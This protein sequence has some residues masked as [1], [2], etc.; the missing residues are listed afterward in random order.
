M[1]QTWR[2]GLGVIV[3]F[4]FLAGAVALALQTT[5]GGRR[6]D[7]DG[8]FSVREVIEENHATTH[9]RTLE[10]L[11]VRAAASLTDW[12]RFD[13]TTTG[14][15]GGP[16]LKSDR[17]GVYTWD[18]AF[19]DVSPAVDLEE[20]YFDVLL[21]SLDL[22]LG[23]QKVAWGKLDRTQ[24]NDLINPLSYTDPFLQ[25][26]EERKIGVPALQASYYL[27]STAGRPAGEPPHR[28]VGAE[29]PS[30][31]VSRRRAVESQ[32]IRRIVI[33]S[34]GFRRLRC[35]RRASPFPPASRWGMALRRRHSRFH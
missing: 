9:E 10:Q 16:T 29:I 23:K 4:Q 5:V 1:S 27:P 21:P 17:A 32:D 18:D 13:S 7:L 28:R 22:R 2:V 33:L 26:E 25:D 34:A 11:R 6:V 12:L 19:Q 24:P 8:T 3:V 14:T 20:A 15:N 35:R 31:S 30:L